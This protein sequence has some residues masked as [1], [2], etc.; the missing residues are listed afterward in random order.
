MAPNSNCVKLEMIIEH[1]QLPCN[2]HFSSF[3]GSP[4][5]GYLS[6]AVAQRCSIKKCFFISQKSQALTATYYKE[7]Q[8]QVFSHEFCEVFKNAFFTEHL[9]ATASNLLY[10]V[11]AQGDIP[12]SFF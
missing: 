7:T 10:V 6:E 4:R 8:V 3:L 9:W 5:L 1:I 2:T 12:I 11:L